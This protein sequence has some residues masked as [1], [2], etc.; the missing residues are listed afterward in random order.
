MHFTP[1]IKN[2]TKHCFSVTIGAFDGIH[3]GHQKIINQLIN[4][5]K[6]KKYKKGLITFHPHPQE[7]LTPKES[8][9]LITTL[10]EKLYLLSRTFLDYIFVLP[11][12]YHLLKMTPES[13]VKNILSKIKVKQIIVGDDFSFGYKRSGNFATLKELG[14]IHGFEVSVVKPV[15]KL[16]G[17][18][19]STRIR[20]LIK[21]GRVDI[22]SCL[23][24]YFPLIIE[25]VG[26]G[27]KIGRNIL[28]IKTANLKTKKNKLLPPGG[29]Y[30]A[31]VEILNK[32]YI[33]GKSPLKLKAVVNIGWSPTFS[34]GEKI[35]EV[36][37]LD[38]NQ[39]IYGKYLKVS[40]VKKIREEIKFKTPLDLLKRIEEDISFAQKY[41]KRG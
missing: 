2:T 37:L 6:N 14:K 1:K 4:I 35:V 24:G 34:K 13:F 23:L 22:A 9:Q 26:P 38:F 27:K 11:T 19:S 28:G 5:S 8:P 3:I 17:V 41:L 16:G 40:L 7:V 12:D 31:W 39:N 20:E 33:N 18:V 15:K 10:S 25:K 36:H 30:C 21:E 32:K 29:V